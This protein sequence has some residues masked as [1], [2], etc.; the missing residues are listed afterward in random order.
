MARC[1]ADESPQIL[2]KPHIAEAEVGQTCRGLPFFCRETDPRY[3]GPDA[4]LNMLLRSSLGRYTRERLLDIMLQRGI[5]SLLG[6]QIAE[7]VH[8]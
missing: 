1:H 7:Q 5:S 2:L 6:T 3:A 8:Y 4:L